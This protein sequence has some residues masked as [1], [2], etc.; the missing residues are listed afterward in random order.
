MTELEEALRFQE[1]LRSELRNRAEAADREVSLIGAVER[2]V[3]RARRRCALAA[4]ALATIVGAAIA[5]AVSASS[6]LAPAITATG[7]TSRIPAPHPGEPA[8]EETPAA[9]LVRSAS[10]PT[11]AHSLN[12]AYPPRVRVPAGWRWHHFGGIFLAVPASWATRRDARRGRCPDGGAPVTVVLGTATV[13]YVPGCLRLPQSSAGPLQK[14]KQ[15][16]KI[17]D[18]S[19]V[20]AGYA[21]ADVASNPTVSLCQRL[22][23]VRACVLWP[24]DSLLKVSVAWLG[25][26]WRTVVEIRHV[27][28]AATARAIFD[29]IRPEPNQRAVPPPHVLR[30]PAPRWGHRT[31]TIL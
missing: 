12:L 1:A 20:V 27:R 15:L 24:G 22:D 3:R 2:R 18:E 7:F 9:G 14:F 21:A 11:L 25:A 31:A 19:G 29:S 6:G 8:A 10:D 30:I 13:R 23:S 17:S 5:V 28:S 16:N 26:A 4:S